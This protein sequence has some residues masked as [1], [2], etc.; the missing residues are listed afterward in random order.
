MSLFN[1]I[2]LAR[3]IEGIKIQGTMEYISK[4][5]R[6]S[7]SYNGDYLSLDE[8][9]DVFFMDNYCFGIGFEM[10]FQVISK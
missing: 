1:N 3:K 2:A 8:K 4:R 10:F 9:G 5:K 7:P 6:I